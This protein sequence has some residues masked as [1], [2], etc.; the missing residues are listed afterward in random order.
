MTR[1]V[2]AIAVALRDIAGDTVATT[3]VEN[4]IG[5]GK[6]KLTPR[7]DDQVD[8]TTHEYTFDLKIHCTYPP[9][10]CTFLYNPLYF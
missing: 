10:L 8:Y 6:S 7:T 9:P 5:K 3:I 4:Y 1:F 2:K